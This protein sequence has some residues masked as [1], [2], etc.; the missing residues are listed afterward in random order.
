MICG[1]QHCLL[2]NL[3]GFHS[4]VLAPGPCYHFGHTVCIVHIGPDPE[5]VHGSFFETGDR[6][7]ET[8][9]AVHRQ[10]FES[11]ALT[12]QICFFLSILNL[13]PERFVGTA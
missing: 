6:P 11:A 10:L 7:R 2:C 5:I 13:I 12:V 3:N 1:G 9:A 8:V 4:A